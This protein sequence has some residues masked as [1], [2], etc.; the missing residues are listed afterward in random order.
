M[1]YPLTLSS[2]HSRPTAYELSNVSQDETVDSDDDNSDSENEKNDDRRAA[3]L[4]KQLLREQELEDR[5]G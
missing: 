3:E 1:F 2:L 4:V 5:L